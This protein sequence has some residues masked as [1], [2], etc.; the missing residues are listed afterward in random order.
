MKVKNHSLLSGVDAELVQNSPDSNGPE[1]VDAEYG[2]SR[3]NHGLVGTLFDLAEDLRT[4]LAA[5]NGDHHRPPL[6]PLL[7]SQQADV[8]PNSAV[9]LQ[10]KVDHRSDSRIVIRGRTGSGRSG[11]RGTHFICDRGAIDGHV[12]LAGK[13]LVSCGAGSAS[14]AVVRLTEPRNRMANGTTPLISQ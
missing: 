8:R 1:I 3:K 12:A 7:R 10:A 5:R 14:D 6:W 9:G 2:W 4:S 11:A 13:E